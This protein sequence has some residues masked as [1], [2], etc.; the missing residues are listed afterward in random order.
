MSSMGQ[1]PCRE[2]EEQETLSAISGEEVFPGQRSGGM[3][4]RER[5]KAEQYQSRR[6]RVL[7]ESWRKWKE[8]TGLHV[9]LC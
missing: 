6:V 9:K 5:V 4:E 1:P 2:H 8:G 3:D 7:G